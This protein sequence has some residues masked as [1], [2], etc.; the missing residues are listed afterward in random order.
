V[1]EGPLK[2]ELLGKAKILH[3]YMQIHII[4]KYFCSPNKNIAVGP[5]KIFCFIAL[6][7]F[8]CIE[9]FYFIKHFPIHGDAYIF[10][11]CNSCT[12]KKNCM[13][14]HHS[15]PSQSMRDEVTTEYAMLLCK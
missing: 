6:F 13:S 7:L 3:F 5:H 14:S 10:L 15:M 1:S 12:C 9:I 2:K 11:K 4:Q 8:L